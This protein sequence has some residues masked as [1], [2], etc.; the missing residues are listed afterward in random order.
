MKCDSS[1]GPCDTHTRTNTQIPTTC[2]SPS[3]FFLSEH[4]SEDFAVIPHISVQ[5]RQNYTH[6]PLQLSP[7]L[8]P[9]HPRAETHTSP[10]LTFTQ[11]RQRRHIRVPSCVAR[12]PA[13]SRSN[14]AE[15]EGE[16][17]FS[18]FLGEKHSAGKCYLSGKHRSEKV[19]SSSACIS[20]YI[21][22]GNGLSR[23]CGLL[24]RVQ[25][26]ETIVGL[27]AIFFSTVTAL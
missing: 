23:V 6:A 8:M 3:S 21:L 1:T 27:S 14:N 17:I 15:R 12:P 5:S 24:T 9:T 2:G 16:G 13:A 10:R 25:C 11:C 22:R 19:C 20:C 4:T 26:R 18:S 7:T